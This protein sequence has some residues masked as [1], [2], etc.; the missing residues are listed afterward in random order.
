MKAGL[1]KQFPFRDSEVTPLLEGQ[2]NDGALAK[3]KS[4]TFTGQMPFKISEQ[5][6][7]DVNAS[8]PF[9]VVWGNTTYRDVFGRDRFTTF[10]WVYLNRLMQIRQCDNE[11]VIS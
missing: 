2:R 7:A 8:R 4:V 1:V 10:C 9:L 3:D 5:F 11:N 6:I